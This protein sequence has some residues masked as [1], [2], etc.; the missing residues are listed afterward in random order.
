MLLCQEEGPAEEPASRS[1]HGGSRTKTRICPFTLRGTQRSP[2]QGKEQNAADSRKACE[3]TGLLAVLS[4][5]W[6][7][8]CSSCLGSPGNGKVENKK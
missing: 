3:H 6:A 8:S 7:V 5:C 1:Q 4:G 2:T